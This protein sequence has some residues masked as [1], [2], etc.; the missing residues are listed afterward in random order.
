MTKN[1]S[2]FFLFYRKGLA[3]RYISRMNSRKAELQDSNAYR[4]VNKFII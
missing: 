4:D 2:V 3:D 1:Y